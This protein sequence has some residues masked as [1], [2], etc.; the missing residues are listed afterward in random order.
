MF[1]RL[2]PLG[3]VRRA[4]MIG[5]EVLLGLLDRLDTK[6]ANA[7]NPPEDYPRIYADQVEAPVATEEELSLPRHDAE[8]AA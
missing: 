5:N 3:H 1:E 6:Y 8:G 4:R 7:L 2:S